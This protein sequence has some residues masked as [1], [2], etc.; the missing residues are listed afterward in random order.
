MQINEAG[1]E[2][3][4]T[5]EGE[6]LSPYQDQKGI[7][8]LGVG[9]TDHVTADSS[10]I[11]DDEAMALLAGDNKVAENA[12]NNALSCDANENQFSAMVCLCFNIGSGN[13]TKSTLLRLFNAGDTD[14]ASAQFLKWCMIS[15]QQSPG[16]LRRRI[17]ERSLF[18]TDV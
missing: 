12:V 14:G 16:L 15:G 18:D 1:L 11:T 7:W 17:A 9:H 3:E 13:F 5:F 6:R 8:T 2:L 10:P 4:K